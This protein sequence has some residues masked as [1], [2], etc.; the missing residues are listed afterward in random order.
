[1]RISKTIMIISFILM[2]F[3]AGVRSQ[4]SVDEVSQTISFNEFLNRIGKNN[5]GYLAE[6]YNVSIAET[7]IIANKV[8]PDPELG[9]EAADELFTLGLAYNL[10]LG[11]KRGARVR[12]AKSQ[13]ELEKLALEYYYQDLRAEAA[14]LFLE[15]MQQKELLSVKRSSYEYML[16][17]SRSDSIR[18]R[19]GEITETD[20]RQS[21]LEAATLLNEVFEQEAVYKSSQVVL[22]QLMGKTFDTLNI[23]FGEWVG[24]SRE[25][26]LP[27]L[28]SLGLANRIDLFVAHKNV[29]VSVNQQKLVEAERKMD[30]GLSLN[31]ER[32]WRGLLP[33][34]NSVRAGVSVPLKFSNLNKGAVKA[35]RLGAEQSKVQQQNAELQVQAEISQAFFFFEAAKK[36]VRQYQTGL[37]DESRK[38]LDGM[39]YRYQRG[40]TSIVEVLIAQRTYNEVQEQYLETMKGYASSLVNLQKACGIWDIE[41]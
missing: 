9:F 30:V 1:M 35:A 28:T 12:L 29:E 20:A 24:L 31:Y 26:I 11:N 34:S 27:A 13:A 21:K 22:N 7:E 40:E 10:E 25:Y 39:V 19:L 8:L 2:N 41:F 5:L 3:A 36:K 38:I 15:A 33:P 23:P 4:S 6:K 18:F 17:L 14:N 32:D 16:Q 37:L